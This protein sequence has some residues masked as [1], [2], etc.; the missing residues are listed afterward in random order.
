M[1]MC[2]VMIFES[3]SATFLPHFILQNFFRAFLEWLILQTVKIS[4]I[5]YRNVKTLLVPRVVLKAA[6]A[7]WIRSVSL[8]LCYCQALQEE[9]NDQLGVLTTA[10]IA[11]TTICSDKKDDLKATHEVNKT[12]HEV[13]TPMLDV[14]DKLQTREQDLKTALEHLET[15]KA[16]LEPVQE[17][18]SQVESTVEAQAPVDLNKGEDELGKVDVS[19]VY[20]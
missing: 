1:T 7:S 8:L 10:E 18:F 16:Q 15:Y 11:A 2:T 14:L 17:V 4:P 19:D 12:L 6:A 9:A 20:A 3:R 13:Q 5:V